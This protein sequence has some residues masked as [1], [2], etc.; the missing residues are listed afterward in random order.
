MDTCVARHLGVAARHLLHVIKPDL[1]RYCVNHPDELASSLDAELS[2]KVHTNAVL[3][4]W[5]T[6]YW[7]RNI[8]VPDM[9]DVRIPDV[10]DD[11]T[12]VLIIPESLR[13]STGIELCRKGIPGGCA[14]FPVWCYLVDPD[15]DI[16]RNE[17]TA[18]AGTYAILVRGRAV[19]DENL[20]GL[21]AE[22]IVQLGIATENARER[23]IHELKF[24][25][26]TGAHLD[27]STTTLCSGSR[28]RNGGVPRIAW[29]R[30][31]LQ[32]LACHARRASKLLGAREVTQ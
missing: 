23:V 30:N 15:A 19:P 16:T 11:L 12:R 28:T 1:A 18:S 25:S 21:S 27:A 7:E 17:R 24:F 9:G 8:R 22:Q 4:D 29:N 26:E 3:A 2:S 6:F 13:I 14:G 5:D 20:K 31:E 32:I 10:R